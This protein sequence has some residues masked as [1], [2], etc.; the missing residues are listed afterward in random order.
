MDAARISVTL[1]RFF[2][3]DE[4]VG[5]Y[6]VLYGADKHMGSVVLFIVSG[7]KNEQDICP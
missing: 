5:Q 7:R 6:I 2:V 3:I 4:T 1:Y